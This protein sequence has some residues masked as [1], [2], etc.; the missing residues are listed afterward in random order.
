[1]DPSCEG[2]DDEVDELDA[3]DDEDAD[4]GR[5]R[6]TVAVGHTWRM[7][8]TCRGMSL[9]DTSS[10]EAALAYSRDSSTSDA[11]MVIMPPKW[12]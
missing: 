9:H 7:P 10:F 5:H 3:D 4:A 2:D 1:M 11:A 12:R 8:A 6:A